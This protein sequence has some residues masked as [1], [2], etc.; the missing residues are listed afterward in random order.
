M[1]KWDMSIITGLNP[2]KYD[3]L[4]ERFLNPE[5]VSMP[6]FDVDFCKDRR[7][8]VIDYVID[9]YGADRVAQIAAFG[10]MAAKGA[11]RDVGRA[12]GLPYALCDKVAKAIPSDLGMT[13]PKALEISKDLKSLYE[14]DV[15]VKELVDTAIKLEGTPR[16]TTT[17]A[18]GIVI[19]DKPVS[20]YVPLAKNDDVVV[21]QF[22]MTTLDELGLLKMDFLALRNLTVLK[23]AEKLI[24]NFKIEDIPED[25]KKVFE[26]Y[27]N[28]DTEGV[29]QFESA[30]MKDTLLKLKPE[31]IE[32]II[33]K[34]KSEL[35]EFTNQF[36]QSDDITMLAF[37]YKTNS[38]NH[39]NT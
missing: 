30:G 34:M 12:L 3:L 36:E 15:Q 23:D 31:N 18:A 11:I 16:H 19:T 10:T 28:A 39:V 37:N 27:A 1:Q 22:D 2:I 4:F 26:L 38:P 32:D 17:H 14:S 21:T 25:D 6:D 20:D 35:R 24:G 8:E 5:R 29:F 7:Q 9:K 33:S 13:I